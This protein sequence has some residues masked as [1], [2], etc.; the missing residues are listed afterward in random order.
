MKTLLRI[1]ASGRE[2]RS[3]TRGMT[4][5][6]VDRWQAAS[7]DGRVVRRDVGLEPPATVSEAWIA[8]VYTPDAERDAAA[9]EAVA[10]SDTLIGELETADVIVIGTPM[11]NFGMPAGLKA[12]V[13]QVVRINRTFSFDPEQ[14]H[15]YQG[16]VGSKPVVLAISAGEG[17]LHPGG[18]L[19][20]LN[21]LE[22]HLTTILQFIGLT[23]VRP[24]RVGYQEFKDERYERSLREAEA[25]IDALAGELSG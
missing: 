3:V 13:D 25:S 22:P 20:Q 6:F 24:V 8:S 14:E 9:Q 10:L 21:F 17:E 5:R 16:L 2:T 23:D 7:P 18:A 1:D 15:P 19:E 12:W 11:Y 4:Q